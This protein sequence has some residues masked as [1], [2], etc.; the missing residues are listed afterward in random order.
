MTALAKLWIPAVTVAALA[1]WLLFDASLGVNWLTWVLA[2]S[3]GL[4]VCAGH[5]E[6]RV[7]AAIWPPLVLACALAAGAP[8]SANRALATFSVFGGLCLLAAA[9]LLARNPGTGW[10]DLPFVVGLP[11]IAP[12]FALIEAGRRSL[13]LLGALASARW[14]AA[15]RGG[16][17][18]L[19]VVTALALLLA[20]ADPILAAARDTAIELID[21]IDFIPRL[22][23]F[24]AVLAGAVGAGGISLRAAAV[25]DTARTARQPGAGVGGQERLI[26]LGSVA[27]LF[28]L[29]LG[30]QAAY[31]FGDPA[32]AVGSGVTY[33]EYARRGFAELSTA[34]TL[35]A[36]LVLALS[37]WGAP[38][39]PDNAG[40]AVSLLLLAETALLLLSAF[41]RVWLYEAAYGFTT[42][43]LYAQVYMIVLGLVLVLLAW[44]LR[45]RPEVKRLLRRAMALGLAAVA[46][47]GCWNHEAWIA[48]WNIDRAAETGR[49]DPGY[50]VWGLSLNAVPALVEGAGRLSAPLAA[51]INARLRDRYVTNTWLR[52]CHWYEW[53]LAHVE[54]AR[55][56]YG[57]GVPIGG[58]RES[59]ALEGCVRLEYLRRS[60]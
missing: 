43:R 32:A 57:A 19:P 48:G 52:H 2:A 36:L 18:A 5:G 7:P 51:D 28:G 42:A 3:A 54:A 47:L 29:F 17:I 16:A 11:V 24:L 31:L 1:N 35:C 56:L 22:V 13:E 44:E 20:G 23:F 58:A 27:A 45:E 33:A 10:I 40:R 4:V 30:L 55:A 25:P 9:M 14:R 37:R 12:V 8:L 60:R 38:G 26:V 46:V 50:L 15:V 34:A 49:L 59:G 41:R 21:R 53:N 39:S 6:R